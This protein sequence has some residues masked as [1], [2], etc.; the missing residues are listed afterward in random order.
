MKEIKLLSEVIAE[1]KDSDRAYSYLAALY[2]KKGNLAEALEI[3]K[4][5]LE[6]NHSIHETICSYSIFL[7]EVGE[8]DW[9]VEVLKKG[10]TSGDCDPEIWNFLGVA[11]W[12][13]RD[14]LNAVEA[15]QK[16]LFL[17]KNHSLV[18]NDLV[19]LSPGRP[20]MSKEADDFQIA[21]R[22]FEKAAELEADFWRFF[23]NTS[24]SSS[25]KY[26][27]HKAQG[28]VQKIKNRHFHY[29]RDKEKADSL[30]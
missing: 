2:K 11:Y 15:Y 26:S 23:F 1:K 20:F 9:A 6:N 14:F 30:I 7:I 24:L 4:R 18:F 29:S 27:K 10:L 13:K 25:A 12:S 17:D 8:Y 3:L 5:E 28:L 22:K 21:I 19:S 16:T